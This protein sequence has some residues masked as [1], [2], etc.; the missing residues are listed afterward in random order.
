VYIG[1][2]TKAHNVLAKL[3]SWSLSGCG[4]IVI[5]PE[6][7]PH[8]SAV[9]FVAGTYWSLFICNFALQLVEVAMWCGCMLDIPTSGDVFI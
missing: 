4:I 7:S 2:A 9:L 8:A 1:N 3:E 6:M 5:R